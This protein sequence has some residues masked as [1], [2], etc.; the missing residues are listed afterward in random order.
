MKQPEPQER[1]LINAL[2]TGKED[3]FL[4]SGQT[5]YETTKTYEIWQKNP[6]RFIKRIRKANTYWILVT[7]GTEELWLPV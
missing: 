3:I 7:V 2:K 5:I 4:S 6:L 1:P